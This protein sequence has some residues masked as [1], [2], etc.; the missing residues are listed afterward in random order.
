VKNKVLLNFLHSSSKSQDDKNDECQ[1][2]INNMIKKIKFRKI[3]SIDV[4]SQ[5]RSLVSSSNQY[6]IIQGLG[7]A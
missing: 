6:N 1:N 3:I 4:K 5:S 7:A 2:I